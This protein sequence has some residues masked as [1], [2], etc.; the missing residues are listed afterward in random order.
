MNR[1]GTQIK[2]PHQIEQIVSDS[3]VKSTVNSKKFLKDKH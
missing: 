3:K 2:R 1:N